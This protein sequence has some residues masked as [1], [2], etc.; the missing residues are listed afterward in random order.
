[1]TPAKPTPSWYFNRPIP[2]EEKFQRLSA[3]ALPSIVLEAGGT[4]VLG[5]FLAPTGKV[6]HEVE[7][8]K[9]SQSHA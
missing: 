1:M 8:D 7:T 4:L 5:G 6:F 9:V 3:I 2:K